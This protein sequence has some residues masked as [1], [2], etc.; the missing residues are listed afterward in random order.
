[1]EN[2]PFTAPVSEFSPNAT[3]PS[4]FDV[5]PLPIAIAPAAP[6]LALPPMAVVF[7]AVALALLPNT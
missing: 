6:A 7:A 1:M 3:L 4:L 2:K 5:A